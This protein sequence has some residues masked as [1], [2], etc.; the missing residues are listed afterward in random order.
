MFSNSTATHEGSVIMT[1]DTVYV[2]EL[3]EDTEQGPASEGS[4][5]PHPWE[6]R[7]YG[8][9]SGKFVI[10]DQELYRIEDVP[11]SDQSER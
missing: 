6:Q 1:F 3:R 4:F 10:I 7:L 9:L 5:V 11:S 2:P 8:Y